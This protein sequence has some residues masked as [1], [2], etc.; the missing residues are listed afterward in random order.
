MIC[1]RFPVNTIMVAK[2][3]K[4]A[5][6]EGEGTT[7]PKSF[8]LC[9]SPVFISGLLIRM[10]Q[11]G[12]V[13]GKMSEEELI[14]LLEKISDANPSKVLNLFLFE[15]SR[16]MSASH[17]RNFALEQ[18]FF[19][20]SQFE[21]NAQL[22][23]SKFYPSIL[24]LWCDSTSTFALQESRLF[25]LRSLRS[26]NIFN[27]C[28]LNHPYPNKTGNA[29]SRSKL[30]SNAIKNCLKGGFLFFPSK[31]SPGSIPPQNIQKKKKNS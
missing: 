5:Q 26:M 17:C 12:Q 7:K 3:E 9:S 30:V 8:T 31:M 16:R 6:V 24:S 22:R 19:Q 27:S 28:S 4:G 29:Y 23:V 11:S 15:T 1:S 20:K 10:A 21:S 25:C 18:V 2:P 14:G 13:G